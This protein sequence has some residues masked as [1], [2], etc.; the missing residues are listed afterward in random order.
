MPRKRVF[1]C[2]HR[3]QGKYCHRCQNKKLALK[4]K[5]GKRA[6][7]QEILNSAPVALDG[8]PCRVVRK[9]IQIV[10]RMKAGESY[11][12]L[13]GKR[14]ISAGC[15][16]VI[17]IPIARDYRLICQEVDGAVVPIE[18]LSHEQYSSKLK[19]GGWK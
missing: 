9:A 4:T 16:D 2:G 18:A 7:W 15:R 3:G 5:Q 17:S 13:R 19:A 6:K 11:V 8:L 12:A 14:L 10:E 1:D